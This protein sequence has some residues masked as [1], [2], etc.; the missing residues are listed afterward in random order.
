MLPLDEFSPELAFLLDRGFVAREGYA[1]DFGDDAQLLLTGPFTLR[2]SRGRGQILLDFGD[3]DGGWI[4]FN[5]LVEFLD[6]LSFS[7]PVFDTDI[8]GYPRPASTAKW[9]IGAWPRLLNLF[10]DADEV[11]K[12]RK[13]SDERQKAFAES[14]LGTT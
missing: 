6:G 3:N 12:L 1:Y 10:S 5:W 13:F 7:D 8:H 9:M 14:W 2:L 4:Y 11:R